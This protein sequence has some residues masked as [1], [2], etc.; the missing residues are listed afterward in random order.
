MGRQKVDGWGETAIINITLAQNPDI[1]IASLSVA[2]CQCSGNRI[3][4]YM[5]YRVGNISK[6]RRSVARL[7]EDDFSC[8]SLS[9]RWYNNLRLDL[10]GSTT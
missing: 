2:N 9:G 5:K 3:I 1:K 4:I 7:A 6:R 10:R 8:L